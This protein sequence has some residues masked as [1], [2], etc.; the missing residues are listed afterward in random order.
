MFTLTNKYDLVLYAKENKPIKFY[1]VA[2][3]GSIHLQFL[4]GNFYTMYQ[5]MKY[6][7]PVLETLPTKDISVGK[8]LVIPHLIL[9]KKFMQVY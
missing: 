5:V 7:Y 1:V 4:L 6:M 9:K 8:N 2:L 3:N